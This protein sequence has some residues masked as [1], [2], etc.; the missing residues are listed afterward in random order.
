MTDVIFS[1]E[2]SKNTMRQIIS[3]SSPNVF[4]PGVSK[5]AIR[6]GNLYG[7][8]N[9]VTVPINDSLYKF[10]K[11]SVFIDIIITANRLTPSWRYIYVD[12]T[13]MVYATRHKVVFSFQTSHLAPTVIMP[14]NIFVK[15]DT[16]A[17]HRVDQMWIER[18]TTVE[19]IEVNHVYLTHFYINATYSKR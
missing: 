13:G 16:F 15:H 18:R 10:S 7:I 19:L 17:W 9:D 5:Y 4:V 14:L 11:I 12:E 1:K 3:D 2:T 6:N 8:T